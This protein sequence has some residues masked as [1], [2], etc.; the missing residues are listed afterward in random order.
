MKPSSL[1]TTGRAAIWLFFNATWTARGV[2]RQHMPVVQRSVPLHLLAW[3]QPGR[4]TALSADAEA[5]VPSYA[6]VQMQV[7]EQELKNL[8]ASLSAGCR[9]QFVSI[10][11]G[12]GPALHTFGDADENATTEGCAMLNG[13]I[14]ET[15]TRVSQEEVLSATRTSKSEQN[16]EGLGCYPSDC[17]DSTDLKLLARF[18]H[19]RAHE[20]LPGVGVNIELNID[21]TS[22]GGSTAAIASEADMDTAAT[23]G[24]V[25]L[26]GS[27]HTTRRGQLRNTAHL[28]A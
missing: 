15:Q 13:T 25:L 8:T 5:Q 4:D 7:S 1:S 20:M 12:T 11:E 19:L 17:T 23:E 24:Q 3:R 6:P 22:H 27:S 10:L 26:G 14:C 18:I 2:S 28:V 9:T 16:V 21:C